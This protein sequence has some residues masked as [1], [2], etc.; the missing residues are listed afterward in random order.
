MILEISCILIIM[1]LETSCILNIMILETSCILILFFFYLEL[2]ALIKEKDVCYL[3]S[4]G[5]FRNVICHREIERVENQSGHFIST[6]FYAYFVS[7][8]SVKV[9]GYIPRESTLRWKN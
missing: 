7:P 1:I 6:I 9:A 4:D 5:Y 3:S 2:L 8:N